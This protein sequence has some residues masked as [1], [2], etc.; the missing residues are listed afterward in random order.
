MN[1][2]NTALRSGVAIAAMISAAS[3]AQA[4]T[5]LPP[6]DAAQTPANASEPTAQG[7]IV[8]T[9]SRIRRNPLD[10]DALNH[11][12]RNRIQVDRGG[13]AAGRCARDETQAIDENERP[14]RAKVA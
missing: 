7:D 2:I 4:Q 12:F 14:A 11:A 5:T 10:L 13:N 6:P 9:G 3:A 8:I 1:R